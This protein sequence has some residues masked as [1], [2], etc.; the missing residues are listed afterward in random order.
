MVGE[1]MKAEK[2]C[3]VIGWELEDGGSGLSSAP[4]DCDMSGDHVAS[5]NLS[6][7]AWL[8]HRVVITIKLITPKAYL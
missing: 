1:T 7:I 5:L 8:P 2:H 3:G 6:F 4:F